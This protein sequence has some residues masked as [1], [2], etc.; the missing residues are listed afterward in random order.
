VKKTLLALAAV[1]VTCA[2][3]GA[4]FA[5]SSSVTLYGVADVGLSFQ[6]HVAPGGSVTG[7]T[8]GGLSGSRWG[9][10]GTEELGNNLKAIFLLESGFDLDAGKSGQGSRLFGRQAYVGLQGNFGAVMLGRQ[11]NALYDLFAAYDPMAAGPNYSLNAVDNQFNGRNDN[12]VKYTGRFG[13]LIATG[14]Y[15][16]GRDSTVTNGGEVPG[17]YQVGKSYGGGVAYATGPASV[18][19]AYDQ[20]QGTTPATSNRAAK[21]LAVGGSYA[22]GDAKVFAGY[23]WMQDDVTST[24]ARHDNLY[25]TGVSYS[26]TPAFTVTGAAYYTDARRD[27][28]DSMMY[29]LNA[30]YAFSK[31][32]DVYAL[33]GYVNN[34]GSAA[35]GVTSTANTMPGANQTGAMLGMRHKF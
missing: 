32:T 11:Q 5:Q 9:I 28:K 13:G 25:W 4:A 30:D 23:R 27:N 1:A 34:H 22:F 31:R 20:Y 17:A 16:F 29:V 14:F 12:A 19:L 35:Y 15:S 2:A 24:V 7:L 21:R 10:R 8:S 3:S 33:I 18:G 26:F 6:N